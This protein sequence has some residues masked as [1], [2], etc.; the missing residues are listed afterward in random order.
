M[1]LS[2]GQVL[3]Q[4]FRIVR[5]VGEGGMGAVYEAEHTFLGR[6]VAIKV[7]SA[8]FA[9]NIDAVR[10]F[11]R[12]AQAAA[13]IGHE[14]ICEVADVGQTDG[15]PYIVMQLLQGKSLA[16]AIVESAPF[17]VGR[18]DLYLGGSPPDFVS[19]FAIVGT[20]L[21]VEVM[22]GEMSAGAGD[23]NGDG[24]TDILVG[25]AGGTVGEAYV[26]YGGTTPDVVPDITF[27]GSAA[28][29]FGSRVARGR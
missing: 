15:S 23:V 7:L 19:D 17:P 25:S 22:V 1:T 14:N 2:V 11:Y 10:R 16:Q 26:F 24:F 8:E 3:D 28:D 21:G 12:E 4:K 9:H 13:H 27:T 18:V 6:R 29:S 5:L 20:E